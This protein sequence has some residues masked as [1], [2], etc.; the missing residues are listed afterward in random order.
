M[1]T[2]EIDALS[3]DVHG[4]LGLALLNMQAVMGGKVFS[5]ASIAGR[6]FGSTYE[7]GVPPTKAGGTLPGCCVVC[8]RL[9]TPDDSSEVYRGVEQLLGDRAGACVFDCY[10]DCR[11]EWVWIQFRDS[12]H[13]FN[14]VFDSLPGWVPFQEGGDVFWLDFCASR[15]DEWDGGK[16]QH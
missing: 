3:K 9:A 10:L 13:G 14:H 4:I 5:G 11:T 15:G 8:P 16:F 6:A 2:K 12:K 7:G 1:G